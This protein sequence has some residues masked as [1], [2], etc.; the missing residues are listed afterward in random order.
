MFVVNYNS[1][2]FLKD[3][4]KSVLHQVDEALVIDNASIDNSLEQLIT[5]FKNEARLIIVRNLV[6]KGFASACNQG[7]RQAKGDQLLFL[8]P[9]CILESNAVSE[10]LKVLESDDSVGMVGGLLLNADGTEQGGG[11]RSVPTPWRSFVRAF[12]LRRFYKRWPKLFD[13]YD[14]CHLPLPSGPE[15]V[16]AISG[17]CMMV[18]RKAIDDIGL[19]DEAYFLHCEDL[20][21]CMRFR[22]KG[23]KVMFVPSA[24][25]FHAFRVCSQNRPIFVEWHKHKGMIRFYGKFFHHQYPGVLFWMVRAG[26][27]LRFGALVG[28]HGVNHFRQWLKHVRV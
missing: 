25:V 1:G 22:K 19:W 28:Y 7:I 20:D 16:E 6:N 21:L 14:L 8:N 12:G 10:M 15:T 4:I 27:W 5:C 24:R 13:D 9:D 3:C 11:R 2:S 17:A 18:K 26:V 23:R